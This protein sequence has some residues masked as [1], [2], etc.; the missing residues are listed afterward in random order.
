VE[1]KGARTKAL[2][3]A[4]AV[5]C[6]LLAL[7][8]T[9]GRAV[10]DPIEPLAVSSPTASALIPAEGLVTPESLAAPAPRP[11]DPVYPGL[12]LIETSIALGAG[13]AWYHADGHFNQKDWDYNLSW[14]TWKKRFVT[15]DAV[16]FDDNAFGIN[17]IVHP[18]DGA[19]YYLIARGNRLGPLPAFL[20]TLVASTFWEFVIEYRE[21]ASIN[22]LIFTPVTGLAIGEPMV[23][24]SNFLRAG[25]PGPL[26]EVLATAMNPID[27]V[28]GWF[29]GRRPSPSGPTDAYGLPLLYRHRLELAAGVGHADFGAA[30]TR[31]EMEVAADVFVDATP[32]LRHPGRAAGL[33]G[34]GALAWLIAGASGADWHAVG[35]RIQSEVALGGWL[36][37][38]THGVEDGQPT[39]SRRLYVGLGTGFEYSSR[40]RPT[41]DED[42][43]GVVRLAGPLVDWGLQRGE[44]DIHLVADAFYDFAMVHALALED[45]IFVNGTGALSSVLGEHGYYFA[46]GLS[47]SL[48]LILEYRRL[49]VGGIV[50]EDDFWAIR[51]RDR[52]QTLELEPAGRDRRGA[53]RLWLAL[54]P[55]L[56]SPLRALLVLDQV[57]REGRF[58]GFDASLSELRVSTALDIK[59]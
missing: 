1:G 53:R 9:G 6:L 37:R 7:A 2:R 59:F 54:R 56:R 5:L 25:D 36:I 10:A 32:T 31:N 49:E 46:Q 43:L 24:L 13:I 4:P 42:A 30:H 22:D 44:L 3:R 38:Q 28:N 29:E 35:A 17:A 12:A 48:R 57:T 39:S 33:V 11:P 8:V 14:E 26:K 52:F 51:G 16:R 21:V 45:Y 50:A 41:F 27:A 20:I 55:W 15:F 23:R 19:G 34:P 18:L 47:T 40:S 58:D